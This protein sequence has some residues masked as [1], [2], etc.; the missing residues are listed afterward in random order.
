MLEEFLEYDFK[1]EFALNL[2]LGG[3]FLLDVH[4]LGEE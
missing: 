2:L 4:L 3:E 1:E